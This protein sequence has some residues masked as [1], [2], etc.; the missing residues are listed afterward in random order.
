MSAGQEGAVYAPSRH[1]LC[2]P[3]VWSWWAAQMGIPGNLH[4][5]QIRRRLRKLHRRIAPRG[6]QAPQ[7]IRFVRGRLWRRGRLRCGFLGQ[8]LVAEEAERLRLLR[9]GEAETAQVPLVVLAVTIRY[10]GTRFFYTNVLVP[11]NLLL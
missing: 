2:H 9:H 10:V 7:H 8:I 6:V 4:R 5:G 1:A 3:S 11:V